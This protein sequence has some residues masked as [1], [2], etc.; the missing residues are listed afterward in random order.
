MFTYK[1]NRYSSVAALA[2]EEEESITTN[3]VF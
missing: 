3:T 1:E 2:K